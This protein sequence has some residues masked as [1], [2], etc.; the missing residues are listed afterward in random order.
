MNTK[1][2]ERLIAHRES[3]ARFPLKIRLRCCV[4]KRYK[5]GNWWIYTVEV[6]N[7]TVKVSH[8]YCTACFKKEMD[9]LTREIKHKTKEG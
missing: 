4:C 9:K 3:K 8:G 6:H 5:I 7:D 1:Q 2:Y